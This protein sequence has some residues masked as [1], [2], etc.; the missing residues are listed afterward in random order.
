MDGEHDKILVELAAQRALLE[1]T[2]DRVRRME[3]LGRFSFWAKVIIWS[4]VLVLPFL[5]L[6][7]IIDYLGGFVGGDAGSSIM[8]LPSPEMIRD[9]FEAYQTGEL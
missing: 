2:A 1:E 7:S 6:G 9:A 3:R 8:G 5:F 4:L